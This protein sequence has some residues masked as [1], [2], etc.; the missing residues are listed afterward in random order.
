MTKPNETDH[1]GPASFSTDG[2]GGW[3]G[4][5]GKRMGGVH[6]CTPNPVIA[7]LREELRAADDLRER[8]VDIL[9]RTA[10]ALKGTEAPLH[11][12]GWHDLPEVA[13]QMA[14]NSQR[15]RQ[16]MFDAWEDTDWLLIANE[17]HDMK[18]PNSNSAPPTVG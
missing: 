6:T 14:A 11:S 12:H 13:E 7:S 10:V 8:M 2:L 15:L 4:R 16:V 3:C 1:A 9:R 17:V 5:C 18:T